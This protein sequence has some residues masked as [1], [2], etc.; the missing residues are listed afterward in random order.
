MSG[1]N[2]LPKVENIVISMSMPGKKVVSSC[3]QGRG[4]N[5]FDR[6]QLPKIFE[7]SL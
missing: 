7:K 3:I 2:D 4:E 5:D 6:K 1:S